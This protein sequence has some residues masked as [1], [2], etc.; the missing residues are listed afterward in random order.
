[1]SIQL[2]EWNGEVLKTYKNREE[3]RKDVVYKDPAAF[4]LLVDNQV[5]TITDFLKEVSNE[6]D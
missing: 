2:T 1:M 4:L 6:T 5:V 3:A